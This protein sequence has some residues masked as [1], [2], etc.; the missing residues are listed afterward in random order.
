MAQL[1]KCPALD[2]Y[3][4]HDFMVCGIQSQVGLCMDSEEPAWDSLS[5]SIC[6]SLTH[7]LSL[8]LTLKI[9]KYLKK[10]SQHKITTVYHTDIIVSY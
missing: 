8:S 6:P 2:F 9:N 1:V 7:M 5:P 4:D 3:S 10:I